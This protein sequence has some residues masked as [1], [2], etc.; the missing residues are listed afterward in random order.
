MHIQAVKLF[1]Y[2]REYIIALC[3]NHNYSDCVKDKLFAEGRR[4]PDCLQNYLEKLILIF[5]CIK[6]N[7]VQ[8]F[9]ETDREIKDVIIPLVVGDAAFGAPPLPSIPIN[10]GVPVRAWFNNSDLNYITDEL[11]KIMLFR[12]TKNYNAEQLTLDRLFGIVLQN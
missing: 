11:K 2:I 8:K 7:D 5:E 6:N 1:F 12:V 4:L 10:G 3:D 9:N